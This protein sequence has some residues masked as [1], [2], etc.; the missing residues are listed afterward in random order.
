M[1]TTCPRACNHCPDQRGGGAAAFT[2]HPSEAAAEL[3]APAADAHRART[4]SDAAPPT[5]QP[6]GG[7]HPGEAAQLLPAAEGAAVA[8]APAATTAPANA[9]AV[10]MPG[11][12][13]AAAEPS[14]IVWH[15]KAAAEPSHIV[16]HEK[17]AAE[18]SHIEGVAP[19]HASPKLEGDTAQLAPV[20]SQ[21]AHAAPSNFAPVA[22]K[23]HDAPVL[24]G[25]SPG[26][27]APQPSGAS[28]ARAPSHIAPQ[29]IRRAQARASFTHAPGSSPQLAPDALAPG[30]G[31]AQPARHPG[32]GL[33]TAASPAAT[34]LPADAGEG[35]KE[36]QQRRLMTLQVGFWVVVI[37]LLVVR[38]VLCRGRGRKARKD[39]NRAY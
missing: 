6:T 23:L 25:V 26:D 12:E 8:V 18:P 15:E 13:K 37:G 24:Q 4:T 17:A 34:P 29:M 38:F 16:W 20:I 27:V 22:S 30:G 21:Q 5:D 10:Q 14:H 9:S 31:H 32:G 28:P 36:T 1:Q 33:D 3:P 7:P 11:H 35:D 39:L 2:Q 19:S